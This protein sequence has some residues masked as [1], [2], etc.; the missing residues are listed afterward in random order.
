MADKDAKASA[1]ESRY[2][3]N[4]VEAMDLPEGKPVSVT[5]SEIVAPDTEKD[6]AG[7]LIRKALVRFSNAK[8][9]LVL[10]K[11]NYRLLKLLHGPHPD[12]WI[13][14]Q[15]QLMR[16]YLPAARAFGV[17]NEMCVRVVPPTGMQIP[18]SV[19]EYMGSATPQEAKS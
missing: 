2:E 19:R 16:R 13:G 5:I 11:T 3:G 14:K 18:K 15:I 17:Q 9:S 4:F 7:K 1:I 12:Q 6:A 8:K 10:N